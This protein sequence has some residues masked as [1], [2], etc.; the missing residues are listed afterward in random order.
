LDEAVKSDG[1]RRSAPFDP[2]SL[3]CL[4]RGIDRFLPGSEV[5]M[6]GG[7]TYRPLNGQ[8]KL[9]L[10][11]SIIPFSDVRMIDRV[12]DLGGRLGAMPLTFRM[13]ALQTLMS[14]SSRSSWIFQVGLRVHEV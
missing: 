3:L 10:T 1:G 2:L 6:D 14:T 4:S 8:Y 13:S 7:G 12:H 9:M 5:E 11:M